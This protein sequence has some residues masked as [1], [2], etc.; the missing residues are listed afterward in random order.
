M[1]I[2]TDNHFA[3]HLKITLKYGKRFTI[4][5][6]NFILIYIYLTIDTTVYMSHDLLF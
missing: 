2:A 1:L 6:Y 4:L 5:I 3:L